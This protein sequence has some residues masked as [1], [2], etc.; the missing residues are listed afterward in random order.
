MILVSL[1]RVE[2]L[3]HSPC[4]EGLVLFDSV[5]CNGEWCGEWTTLRAIW[6]AVAQPSFS[7]WL[8]D[9]GLI[10]NSRAATTGIKP[11][12]GRHINETKIRD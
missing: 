7:A 2:L 3:K 10:P 9:R 6:L 1:T 4:E 5:A 12:N 11:M 8:R